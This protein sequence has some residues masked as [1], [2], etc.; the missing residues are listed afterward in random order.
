MTFHRPSPCSEKNCA[1]R[2]VALEIQPHEGARE[3]W[4]LVWPLFEGDKAGDL[5]GGFLGATEDWDEHPETREE[6]EAAIVRQA[7]AIT[8][9]WG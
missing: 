2:I 6:I 8:F 3:M 7:Q 1:R 4:N 5:L 9:S